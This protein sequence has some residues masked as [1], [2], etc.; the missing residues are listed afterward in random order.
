MGI[1][2]VGEKRRFA[3]FVA[4]YVPPRPGTIVS[5]T[6]EQLGTHD[7]LCT[8]TIGQGARLPGMKEK[9]FVARKDV[10]SNEM[11]VVPGS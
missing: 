1:C 3:D 2:F 8:Y 9:W 11:V 4:Q 10:A 5:C 7:G 6:G